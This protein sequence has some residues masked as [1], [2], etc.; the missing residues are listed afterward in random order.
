MT[1]ID[2]FFRFANIMF[3]THFFVFGNMYCKIGAKSSRMRENDHH[4][5]WEKN[6]RKWDGMKIFVRVCTVHLCFSHIE[7]YVYDVHK[8]RP[9]THIT[10]HTHIY[11]HSLALSFGIVCVCGECVFSSLYLLFDFQLKIIFCRYILCAVC[12][13]TEWY[14]VVYHRIYIAYVRSNRTNVAYVNGVF[15]LEKLIVGCCCWFCVFSAPFL[16]LSRSLCRFA[17]SL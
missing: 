11:P 12:R 8:L 7:L 6:G 13:H 5:N 17:F 1:H 4:T 15:V 16:F 14:V 9:L 10:S 2:R 3:H